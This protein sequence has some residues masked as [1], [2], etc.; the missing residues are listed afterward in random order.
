MWGGSPGTA[1][2]LMGWERPLALGV[3]LAPGLLLPPVPRLLARPT[4]TWIPGKG[5][6]ASPNGQLSIH[7]RP[8][9]WMAGSGLG[10]GHG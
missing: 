2:H 7:P 5:S 6:E 8:W 9:G 3:A 10:W 1:G 4:V